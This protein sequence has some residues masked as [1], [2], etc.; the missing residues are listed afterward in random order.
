MLRCSFSSPARH[1]ASRQRCLCSVCLLLLAVGCNNGNTPNKSSDPPPKKTVLSPPT[2]KTATITE[3][4]STPAIVAKEDGTLYEGK[5]LSQWVERLGNDAEGRIAA[6]VLM[7]AGEPAIPQLLAELDSQDGNRRIHAMVILRDGRWT[8]DDPRVIAAYIASLHDEEATIRFLAIGG[9]RDAGVKQPAVIDTMAAMLREDR[10]PWRVQLLVLGNFKDLGPDAAAATG[11]IAAMLAGDS[12]V[13][14]RRKA[15]D[16]LVAVGGD[17][18]EVLS[19]LVGAMSDQNSKLSTESWERLKRLG[20]KATSAAPLL[21]ERLGGRDQ[22]LG[23]MAGAVLVSIGKS[24]VPALVTALQDP[25]PRARQ[26]A[27]KVLALI[28]PP[29]KDAL[30]PLEKLASDKDPLTKKWAAEAIRVIQGEL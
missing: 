26:Q 18:P 28:G 1:A 22:V 12:R 24:A 10:Q 8:K 17:R 6:D 14:A 29:A 11:A 2:V 21:I 16:T 13:F 4:T 30:G 9:L 5:T 19:A 27:V 25:R 15:L 3:Q 20:P 23:K 7:Q